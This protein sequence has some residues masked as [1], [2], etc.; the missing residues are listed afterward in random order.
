M[1]LTGAYPEVVRAVVEVTIFLVN[2]YVRVAR[3]IVTGRDPYRAQ[4]A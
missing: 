4:P 3:S 1:V 2:H